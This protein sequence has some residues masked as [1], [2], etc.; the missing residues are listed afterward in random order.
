MK[1]PFKSMKEEY[2]VTKVREAMLYRD[3]KDPKVA[4]AGIES[5]TGKK[6][7]ARKEL[8]VA[9]ERIRHRAL[10]GIVAKGRAGLGYFSSP[11]INKATGKDKRDLILEE[12]RSSAE[13]ERRV[14]AVGLGQQGAWTR[15]EGVDKRIV[16]WSECWGP[17]FNRICFQIK[18]VYDTLPSPTNL[19]VWGKAET[20]NCPL[21]NRKGS[22]QHLL[23]SCPKALGEGRYR[24]RH[25]QVLREIAKIVSMAIDASKHTS[26]GNWKRID[27]V[28]SG[29]T[30]KKKNIR[31]SLLSTAPDWKMLV[32]LDKQ[33]KFPASV[34]ETSLR[35]D[36]IIL[37]ESTRQI[38]IWEL[39]V[40]WEENVLIANE[41]KRE[42]YD[43]LIEQCKLK[44]WRTHFDPIEV[45]CRGF[46]GQSISK[47]LSKIGIFG[48][49]KRKA[50]NNI[51]KAAELS[52]K[53]L[54]LL[55]AQNWKKK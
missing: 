5:K 31:Q 6:W 49:L 43:E 28:K 22:L 51:L 16:T 54:F 23:S 12:V 21:C 20:P 27:F 2:R 14:K 15:W 30:K 46:A 50:L 48:K 52:S 41:R 40:C 26:N 7:N 17:E 11:Q 38:I 8:E 29:E 55:R 32:D 1:L 45:G 10:V 13:E 53:W 33:L 3:S 42:K 34:F 9:E 4:A 25:D 36:L 47:A 39:T 19:F 37:S 35:P 44:G 18:A 24:W